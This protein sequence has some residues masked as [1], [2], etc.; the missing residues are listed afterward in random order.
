MGRLDKRTR[1][2][3]RA[4]AFEQAL[5]RPTRRAVGGRS[6]PRIKPGFAVTLDARGELM[7]ARLLAT[8]AGDE[9][10]E[11]LV[12]AWCN[13]LSKT[14]RTLG[15]KAAP[16][17]PPTLADPVSRLPPGQAAHGAGIVAGCGP[18]S[19]PYTGRPIQ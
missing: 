18:E 17:R 8:G 14:L 7:R 11:P 16:K 4:A 15:R 12:L 10:A 6:G 3:H 5:G 1:L 9:R 2:G 13:A 19:G